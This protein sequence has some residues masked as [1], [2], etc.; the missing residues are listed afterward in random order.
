MEHRERLVRLVRRSDADL[1]EAALLCCVEVQPE[2]DVDLA[3]LRIDAL[4][5]GLRSSGFTPGEAEAD[6]RALGHYLAVEQGFTG[7]E[8]T[9][10]DPDNAL[11]TRVLDRKRGL[12]I[13]LSILFVS[14]ARRLDVPAFPVNLPGHVVAAVAGPQRPVVVDPFHRGVLL[15]DEALARRL[16]EVSAGRVPFHRAM[17]RPSP[18]VEVVR[19]LLNNLTRDFLG[20]GDA[21]N[22][23]WTV[24]LKLALPNQAPDDH[25]VHGELLEQVGRYGDAATAFETYLDVTD[26]G[27]SDAEEVRRAAIRAK[28]RLN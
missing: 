24:E 12:P 9:Y 26:G 1:A 8:A 21:P 20:K 19:R 22:A 14:I 17:L 6:A 11:L 10:H 2:L 7:D 3:L 18:A 25:R 16:S 27:A 15:D 5:D 28:A 4:A 23:L 13:T